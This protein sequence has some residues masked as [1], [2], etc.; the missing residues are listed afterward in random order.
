MS[1]QPRFS[2]LLALLLFIFIIPLASAEKTLCERKLAE[3][4][5]NVFYYQRTEAANAVECA[6]RCVEDWEFCRS[7]ALVQEKVSPF[8]PCFTRS[9]IQKG[10]IFVPTLWHQFRAAFA[11]QLTA[12]DTSTD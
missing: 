7:A 2:L 11:P 12:V 3:M 6:E 8:S 10:Q 4:P 5:P 1:V 9:P